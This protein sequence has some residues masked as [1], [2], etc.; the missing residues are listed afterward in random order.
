MFLH[1]YYVLFHFCSKA[2]IIDQFDGHSGPVTGISYHCVPGQVNSI[3]QFN[4]FHRMPLQVYI[5]KM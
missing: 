1:V 3:F 4:F 2:G 5:K